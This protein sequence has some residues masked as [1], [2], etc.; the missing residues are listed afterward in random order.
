M[1]VGRER[2]GHPKGPVPIA[3]EHRDAVVVIGHREVRHPIAIEVAASHGYRMNPAQGA[4]AR[5][6]VH[7][8]EERPI[9]LAQQHRDV[10]AIRIEGVEVGH[11]EV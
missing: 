5:R 2:P 11:R 10:V 1:N 7:R 9:A 3:E 6:V 4:G 8:L